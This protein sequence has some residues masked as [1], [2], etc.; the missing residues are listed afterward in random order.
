MNFSPRLNRLME[1]LR[2]LPGVGPKSA[3]RM[4]FYLLE[5]DREGAIELAQALQSAVEEIAH[6]ASCR[7]FSETEL[8][9]ICA[10]GDRNQQQLCI[11]ENPADVLVMEST[12]AYQGLYFVLMGHLSPLDGIG[13]DE[14][15]FSQLQQRLQSGLEEVIIALNPTIEGEATAMFIADMAKVAGVAA[16]RLAH[17]IPMG[18]ELGYMDSNTLAHAMRGRVGV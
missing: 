14:L 7:T 5:R 6:C 15:G 10:N 8:C 12:G 13:P 16:T 18:S 3:Q 2:C 1:T 4:A 9:Q 17:G 11:V